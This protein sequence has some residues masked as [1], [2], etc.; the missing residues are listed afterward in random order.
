MDIQIGACLAQ[1]NAKV[2]TH[3]CSKKVPFRTN[4]RTNQDGER[5]KVLNAS[6]HLTPAEEVE[7]RKIKREKLRM[8]DFINHLETLV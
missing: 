3:N 2:S 1:R 5:L 7:I 4:L 8:K 6:V